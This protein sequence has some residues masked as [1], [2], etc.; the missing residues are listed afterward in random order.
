MFAVGAGQP[1]S[2]II[3]D[4]VEL[5]EFVFTQ[6]FGAQTSDTKAKTSADKDDQR[7]EDKCATV[8]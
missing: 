5:V 2:A 8:G 4:G 6:A 7:S 1:V 3:G